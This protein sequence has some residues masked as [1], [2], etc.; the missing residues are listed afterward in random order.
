MEQPNSLEEF[1][2]DNFPAD[3]ANRFLFSPHLGHVNVFERG[4]LCKQLAKFLRRDYYKISLIEGTGML[5]YPDCTVEITGKALAFFNP[6]LSYTWDPTSEQKGYFCM[7]N[8]RF[9]TPSITDEIVK[10]SALFNV[11]QNRVYNLSDEQFDNLSFVF[12]KM[13]QEVESD[14]IK[15]YDLLRHYLHLIFHEVDKMQP[16]NSDTEKYLNASERISSLFIEMLERQFPVDSTE[17]ALSLKSPGGFAERLSVHVNHLNR[18]VKEVTGKSTS[19][20]IA[21]RVAKEATSLLAHTDNSVSDIAYSLGFEHP[22][23]FNNFFKRHTGHTPRLERSGS[24]RNAKA[25]V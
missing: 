22:S 1:Y 11:T 5:H 6:A 14:Y 18:A 24:K 17:H 7:F 21:S 15:K 3:K 20:L 10:G 4:T 25:A 23:N 9:I 8:N 13:M 2:R 19:E 16:A 12:Q